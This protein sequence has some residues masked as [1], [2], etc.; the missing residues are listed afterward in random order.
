MCMQCAAG[1]MAA[2]TAATGL[3]V[4][5]VAHSPRWLTPPRL[6][7]VTGLLVAGGVLAGGLVAA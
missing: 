4:W 5:L 1:A 6:K 3:R 7:V 2:G